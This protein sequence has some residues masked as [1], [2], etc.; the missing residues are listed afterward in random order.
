MRKLWLPA[1]F[2][3]L[4]WGSA[5]P[6]IKLTYGLYHLTDLKQQL[7]FAGVRFLMAGFMTLL[8]C[9]R[10]VKASHVIK[11][12][13]VQ[14]TI[15][16]FLFYVAVSLMTGLSASLVLGLSSIF[17]LLVAVYVFRYEQ[18]TWE[19]SLG[20]FLA[21]LG[22]VCLQGGF[23]FEWALGLLALSQL[24]GSFA[25]GLARRYGQESDVTT[26]SGAQ[27]AFGASL[28][29]ILGHAPLPME[30]GFWLLT[31]YLALVAS[32]ANAI[33][34]RLVQENPVSK[35]GV[36][37]SLIPLFGA[38]LSVIIVHDVFNWQALLAL[39][40]VVSGILM[41]VKKK[42]TMVE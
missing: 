28:L 39:I 21:F 9:H 29:L 34:F 6:V 16:Y 15:Q 7:T 41:V 12:G 26:L 4:L 3:A 11:L 20:C 8:F 22:V 42:R 37:Q 33:W 17:T 32:L 38:F 1:T 2:C 14:T 18:M 13:L 24:S 30:L 40:L 23:H 10:R 5:A 27:F 19:K 31:A 35:V 36:F 25:I